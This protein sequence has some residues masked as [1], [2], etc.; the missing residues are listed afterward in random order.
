MK[1]SMTYRDV[2]DSIKTFS[3]KDAYPVERW[4][5][6]FE[7]TA[8]LYEWT[9][10]QKV[11][12]AKKSLSGPAKMLIKSEGVIKTWKKLKTIL[13]DKFLDKVSSAQLHEM[14]I[15]RKSTKEETVQEYHYAMKELAARGK[16]EPEALIQY[17]ID[18][19]TDDM[20]NKLILY[21]T[22]KLADFKEMLKV[23]EII[24]K[25]NTER[26]REDD[27]RKGKC[28]EKNRWNEEDDDYQGR[29][30]IGP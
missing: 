10:L 23:Y 6:D 3:G 25:R 9:E 28:N 18:N 20:L 4:I 1:F 26:E 15:K 12:F 13:Q 7:D 11:V 29:K 30:G 19:I 24:R 16:I 21:R 8:E 5:S 14:L 27:S 2:E 17:V 22:K